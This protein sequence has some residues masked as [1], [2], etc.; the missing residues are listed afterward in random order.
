MI[1]L[2]LSLV[3]FTPQPDTLTLEAC[4]REA[5]TNW[6]SI[7]QTEL[8]QSISD[9]RSDNLGSKYLP[10]VSL[11]GQAAY[12]TNVVE[13][14]FDVPG[15]STAGIPKD[16]Y[17]LS[18]D[19]DQLIYDGGEISSR[20]RLSAIEASL[21]AI[22]TEVVLHQVRDRVNSLFFE[23]LLLQSEIDLTASLL[24]DLETR[25]TQVRASV[26]GG[27]ALRTDAD[28]LE[29]EMIK[30]SQDA[31]DAAF[32]LGGTLAA[33]SKLIGRP[34]AVSAKLQAPDFS[35]TQGQTTGRRP[36]FDLFAGK[37]DQLEEMEK[38]TSAALRPRLSGFS[39]AGVGSPP[40]LDLFEDSFA[41][42]LVVG[43]RLHWRFWDWSQTS[44]ERQI[45]QIE[46]QI[47]TSEEETFA[48]QLDVESA[49]QLSEIARL[50]SL[51]ATDNDVIILRTRIAKD[52]A[53]RLES[54]VITATDYLI[55]RSQAHRA[56]L[57][58]AVHA[59]QLAAAKVKYATTIGAYL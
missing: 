32:R 9:L 5:L 28:V 41:P 58:K 8:K 46:R 23:A 49:L 48:R 56:E 14:P 16:Q 7:V 36:E 31:G 47:V 12:H 26:E 52:A 3:A 24:E 19:V 1:A 11:R 10:A 53:A 17:A 27:V 37:S 50:D 44:R 22:E 6:P 2:L 59:I 15:V 25:L 21:G 51:L 40:D 55:E 30:V 54:G 45:R 39:Q 13:F 4:Y 38:L 33:L 34:I 29:A 43:V 18:L 35:S 57:R 42:Y 20:K